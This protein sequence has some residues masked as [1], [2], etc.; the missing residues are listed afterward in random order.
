M[1]LL[2][3]SLHGVTI[4]NRRPP[5][6]HYRL[7][8]LHL[9]EGVWMDDDSSRCLP[10]IIA[11]HVLRLRLRQ[12]LRTVET[13]GAQQNF[14][15]FSYP[16]TLSVNYCCS[17]APPPTIS[18]PGGATPS[19]YLHRRDELIMFGETTTRITLCVSFRVA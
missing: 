13:F 6:F 12:A 4:S 5:F 14:L 16:W 19:P 9:G 8:Q 3:A 10:V 1:W 15:T 18:L 17:V 2:I 7:I 11:L